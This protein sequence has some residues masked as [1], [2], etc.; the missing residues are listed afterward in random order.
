[1]ISPSP[2]RVMTVV[3]LFHLLATAVFAQQDPGVRGGI[4]NTAAD[5]NAGN[6]NPASAGDQP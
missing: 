1:M 5:Y 4:E 6:S 3:G 2:F